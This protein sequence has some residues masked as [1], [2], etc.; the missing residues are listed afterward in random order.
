MA[1]Y[2]AIVARTHSIHEPIG[3]VA[4]LRPYGVLHSALSCS[5]PSKRPTASNLSEPLV[6][7]PQ[8]RFAVAGIA[9]SSSCPELAG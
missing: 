3:P 2:E 8:P 7:H 1:V 9:G 6:M 5:T 4:L